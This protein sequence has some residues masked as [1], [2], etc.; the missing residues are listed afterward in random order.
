MKSRIA[1]ALLFLLAIPIVF[2]TKRY[3]AA[4][5]NPKAKPT[6]IISANAETEEITPIEIPKGNGW[7]EETDPQH[8][9][10]FG[11]LSKEEIRWIE[12]LAQAHKSLLE[13]IPREDSYQDE[14]QPKEARQDR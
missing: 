9:I 8:T 4:R 2:I 10:T 1:F 7:Y 11:S 12:E 13:R 5:E 3:A 6:L 14:D